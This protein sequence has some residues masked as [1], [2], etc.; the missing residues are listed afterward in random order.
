MDDV[1]D[2][3]KKDNKP[4][5][6][7]NRT[8][9]IDSFGTNISARK[10]YERAE[11]I[12]SAIHILTRHVDSTEPA[13]VRSRQ[14]SL[15]VLAGLMLLKDEMRNHISPILER[16]LGTIRTLMSAVRVLSASGHI[17]TQNS[18]TL[19]EALDELAHFLS[20]SQ[21]TVLSESVHISRDDFFGV[22]TEIFSKGQRQT[23]RAQ[24]TQ[25]AVVKDT[26]H[27]VRVPHVNGDEK[28][29]RTERI[30]SMLGSQGQLGIKDISASLPEYSE[31][32]IQREL[33]QLVGEGKVKKTGSKR[34]SVYALA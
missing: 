15:D 29:V 33:K 27:P 4:H 14:E 2:P 19:V 9:R 20:S 13:R 1:K 28:R 5:L 16:T 34:W 31:K 17:S 23:I 11:R 21:K 24:R 32:M 18:E 12:A 7:D 25:R 8:L 10:A 26:N 22:E 30:V 6:I 3:N